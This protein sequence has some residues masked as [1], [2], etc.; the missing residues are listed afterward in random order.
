MRPKLKDML[1][2]AH[3]KGISGTKDEAP[4]APLQFQRS[5]EQ[6]GVFHQVPPEPKKPDASEPGPG[7]GT[8]LEHI[9]DT[10]G[11]QLEHIRDTNGTQQEHKAKI[12]NTIGTQLEHAKE[13]KIEHNKDTNGTHK[14]HNWNT[15][16]GLSYLT[17]I[18][19]QL[20]ILF[21]LSCKKTRS[22]MT[23][24][25]ALHN[26][27]DALKIR[28]G[29]VKT[30]LRRLEK[31]EFIRS[32]QF[33]KGRGGWTKFELPDAIYRELLEHD[34]EHNWNTNGTQMEHIR[35]T[36]RNTQKDTSPSSSSSNILKTTTIDE[37]LAAWSFDIEKYASWGFFSHHIKTLASLRDD[38][39]VVE[40][41]LIEYDFDIDHD[42]LPKTKRTS[43]IN[44]ILGILRRG[45]V[46]TSEAFRNEQ[47][48]IFAEIA[49]RAE[50]KRKVLLEEKFSA[51]ES[52]LSREDRNQL[53]PSHLIY[54]YETYGLANDEV[55]TWLFNY[56]MNKAQG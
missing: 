23:E 4:K 43:H 47:E 5:W 46:Y 18:Q 28:L 3:D 10:S 25:F 36:Q 11:T 54:P 44:F 12:R 48:A 17:G 32:V 56:F 20:V 33:K 41:C 2:K 55:R 51:W 16:Y 24:E 45:G 15:T 9:K 34:K 52:A 26:I 31:K 27:A 49:R 7:I 29:S 39:D 13:H 22:H 35:N 21:Y 14:E 19:K 38:P 37:Q 40:Q 53:L 42:A 6:E 8:Q 1:K 50:E 30:S